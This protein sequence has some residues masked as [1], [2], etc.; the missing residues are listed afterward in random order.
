MTT[1]FDLA[2]YEVIPT[3][4]EID[5]YWDELVLD[6]SGRV[7]DNGQTTLFYDASDEPPDPDDLQNHIDFEVAQS[8]WEKQHPD[9]KPVRPV[10]LPL[11]VVDCSFLTQF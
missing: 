1:F 2:Q 9:F 8:D 11:R 7:E 10:V 6:C 5:P 3:K 4:I